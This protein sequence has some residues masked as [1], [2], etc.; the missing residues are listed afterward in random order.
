MFC[1]VVVWCTHEFDLFVIIWVPI[2]DIYTIL[3]IKKKKIFIL[4]YVIGLSSTSFETLSRHIIY[5]DN[6]L[7]R[8]EMGTTCIQ[9]LAITWVPFSLIK[10]TENIL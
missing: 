8:N 1:C 9:K 10:N 4:L 6:F 5:S 7:T 2:L 3:K